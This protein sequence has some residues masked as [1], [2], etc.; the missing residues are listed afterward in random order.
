MCYLKFMLLEQCIKFFAKNSQYQYSQPRTFQLS[1]FLTKGR[2]SKIV[3]S[4]NEAKRVL[5]KPY[6]AIGV[7]LIIFTAEEGI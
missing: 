2:N 3:I 7:R 1:P 5:C 4:S 6:S